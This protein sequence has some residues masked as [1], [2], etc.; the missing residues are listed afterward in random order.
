[1]IHPHIIDPHL[2][3]ENGSGIGAA[4]PT[5]AHGDVENDKERVVE[6][7]LAAGDYVAFVHGLVER[8]IHVEARLV[9]VP[10]DS[11]EVEA[12]GKA[13]IVGQRVRG[14]SAVNPRGARPVHAAVNNGRLA[15][16]VLHDVDLAAVG[17]TDRADVVSSSQKAGHI[18]CP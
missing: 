11:E 17:K 6:H 4:G 14:G 8:A 1:M 9:C 16:D 13:P 15:S 18:P 3:G 7:P 10:L 12:V 2:L 5:A